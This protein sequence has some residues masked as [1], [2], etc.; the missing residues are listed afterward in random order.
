MTIPNPDVPQRQAQS[1]AN[2]HHRSQAGPSVYL[3]HQLPPRCPYPA[4]S[5]HTHPAQ[6]V[7]Q[8]DHPTP[9]TPALSRASELT[10]AVPLCR[11]CCTH[12][13]TQQAVKHCL[14][15]TH[16]HAGTSGISEYLSTISHIL[17][18]ESDAQGPA[19]MP[20]H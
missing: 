2:Q 19:C 12:R 17:K 1:L 11:Y 20:P 15:S 6:G 18:G 13:G 4:L 10:R 16:S 8:H 5:L 9:V 14:L 7:P 3:G